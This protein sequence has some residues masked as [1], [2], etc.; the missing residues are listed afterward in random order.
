MA[1]CVSVH[2]FLD[3]SGA[4]TVDGSLE[5]RLVVQAL[6]INTLSKLTY[7]DSER[8]DALLQD[9]FPGVEFRDIEY[10]TLRNA[11]K[12]VCSESH[13]GVIDS[14][15]LLFCQTEL[16]SFLCILSYHFKSEIGID[17]WLK[18]SGMLRLSPT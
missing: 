9:V 12:E 13:L 14:Q 11:L 2:L 16:L 8:F 3:V 4:E 15:V 7:T 17:L 18:F 1:V 10:E 6:R 5:A